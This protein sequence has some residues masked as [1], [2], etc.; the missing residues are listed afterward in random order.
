MA[1]PGVC[2][3]ASEREDVRAVVREF[4]Q[5]GAAAVLGVDVRTLARV[6]SGWGVLRV[7]A[8]AIRGALDQR[9]RLRR[10]A[11]EQASRETTEEKIASIHTQTRKAPD[12]VEQTT[13]A[14]HRERRRHA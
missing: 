7:T 2:M 13:S 11:A 9:A 12:P 1:G 3:T 8:A 10:Q 5:R 6:L 4:G 14:A